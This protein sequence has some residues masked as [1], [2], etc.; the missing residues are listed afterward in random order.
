MLSSRPPIRP[1]RR[2]SRLGLGLTFAL[3]TALLV[4]RLAVPGSPLW[5]DLAALLV[6]AVFL[7]GFRIVWRSSHGR[8]D[9]SREGGK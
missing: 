3:L 9:S 7:L 5:L 4:W 6:V 8:S 1:M 2:P